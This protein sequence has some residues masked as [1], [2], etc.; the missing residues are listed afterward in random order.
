MAVFISIGERPTGGY[1]P[2]VVSA[3]LGDSQFV[4]VYTDGEPSRDTFVTQALTYPWVVA[5]VPKTPL[6]MVTQ[7]QDAN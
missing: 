6:T 3:T 2:R 5:I 1:Q 7:R 4:V